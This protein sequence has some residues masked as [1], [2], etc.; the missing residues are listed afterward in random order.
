MELK[1]VYFENTGI[2]NTEATLQ[3]VRQRARELG[4][5]NI[6]IASTTGN[7]AIKAIDILEDYS[8]E[9]IQIGKNEF[10]DLF[11]MSG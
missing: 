6:V 1:T 5:K 2:E 3:I 7:S 10:E 8:K 9:A 11:V 4:I